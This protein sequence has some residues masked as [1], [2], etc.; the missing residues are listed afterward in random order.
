MVAILLPLVTIVVAVVVGSSPISS[1]YRDFALGFLTA[2]FVASSVR[3]ARVLSNA[4]S[5]RVIARSAEATAQ[6]VAGARRR[7]RG[8]RLVDGRFRGGGGA[9]DHVLVGPGGV[10][11]IE[12]TWTTS[13][14]EITR[15]RIVG[16]VGRDPVGG[17]RSAAHRVEQMLHYGAHGSDATVRPMVVVWGPGGLALEDGWAVTDGVLVCEGRKAEQWLAQLDGPVMGQQTVDRLVRALTRQLTPDVGPSDVPAVRSAR[18]V[19]T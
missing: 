13:I 11:V 5:R 18:M 3:C 8:W 16:A 7:R 6:A 15:G 4:V 12:S 14:S 17:A 9:T 10:Y 1:S 2:A 19:S